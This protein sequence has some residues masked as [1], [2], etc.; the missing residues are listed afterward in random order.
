MP[1]KNR[2]LPVIDME[3]TGRRLQEII[4]E[5]GYTVK[6]LQKL[7]SISSHQSIY[8]WYNGMTIP[9]VDNFVALSKL[10]GI[11]IDDLVVCNEEVEERIRNFKIEEFAIP[12]Y[13]LTM[14]YQNN[15]LTIQKLA[16]YSIYAG[17]RME[18]ILAFVTSSNDV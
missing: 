1:R 9:S 3:K 6:Q 8:S 2:E 13:E 12:V 4:E 5:K 16:S 15:T 17:K 14:E 10:L 18:E 11:P 7:L